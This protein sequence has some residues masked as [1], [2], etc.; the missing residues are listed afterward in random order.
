MIN[1]IT[2]SPEGALSVI[3]ILAV[4]AFVLL[5]INA[6]LVNKID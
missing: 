3:L 6:H 4:F 2:T 5:K 1:H